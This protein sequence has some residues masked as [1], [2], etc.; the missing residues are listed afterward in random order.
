MSILK[1]LNAKGVDPEKLGVDDKL[2]DLLYE[3]GIL[4]CVRSYFENAASIFDGYLAIKPSSER[5]LIGA[6]LLALSRPNYKLAEEVLK[7]DLLTNHP[8]S[9]FGKAYLGIVYKQTNRTD[10]AKKLFEEVSKDDKSDPAASALA[11]AAL[12]QLAEG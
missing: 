8:N 4:G 12:E 6:G 9:S 3:I 10:E 11:K 5:A 2:L 1:S 7:E